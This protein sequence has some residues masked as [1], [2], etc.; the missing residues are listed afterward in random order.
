VFKLAQIYTHISAE[1]KLPLK[2]AQCWQLCSNDASAD[3]KTNSQS[4][5]SWPRH[6]VYASQC[7]TD[8]TLWSIDNE[9]CSDLD[10]MNCSVM[11]TVSVRCQIPVNRTTHF[12]LFF[13]P[14][15]RIYSK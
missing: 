12:T 11:T 15:T 3:D 1:P 13:T 5:Q 9:F 7:H 4:Y 8:A 2:I 10:D 6:H 14:L